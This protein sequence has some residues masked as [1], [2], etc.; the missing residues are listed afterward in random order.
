MMFMNMES[1]SANEMGM[2]QD[3]MND[4]SNESKS[5][6]GKKPAVPDG[7]NM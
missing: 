5:E 2:S 1:N 3:E 7:M 4:G 6:M